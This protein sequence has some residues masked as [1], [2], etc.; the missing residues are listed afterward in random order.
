MDLI[1]SIEHDTHAVLLSDTGVDA[2]YRPASDQAGAGYPTRILIRGEPSQERSLSHG[3]F[4]S[5]LKSHENRRHKIMVP[6][7]HSGEE[8]GGAP[9][10]ALGGVVS[11]REG[12][13]FEVPLS[14]FGDRTE[15][16]TVKLR[17]A[18]GSYRPGP[19]GWWVAEVTR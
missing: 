19:A 5:P 11:L 6:R 13:T 2:V 10:G 17:V 12:D 7:L 4:G 8:H 15:T 18:P 1:S 9:A 14:E 3:R 16:G